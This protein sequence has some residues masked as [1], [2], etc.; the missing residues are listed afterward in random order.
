MQKFF[1]SILLNLFVLSVF[2]GELRGYGEVE[3]CY[4]VP[5]KSIPTCDGSAYSDWGGY[6]NGVNFC[7]VSSLGC[8]M[9]VVVK[10]YVS[11]EP[12]EL[13][14]VHDNLITITEEQWVADGRSWAYSYCRMEYP[15]VGRYIGYIDGMLPFD[16]V[17]MCSLLYS[18]TDYYS[19]YQNQDDAYEA[20]WEDYGYG[21]FGSSEEQDAFFSVFFE[22]QPEIPCEI[23]ISRLMVST[24]DA[25]RL[26]AEKYTEPSLV[27]Q[28]N[29]EKCYVK[30]ESGVGNLNINF[31]GEIYH[32]V[33]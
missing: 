4:V 3:R 22:P 19:C 5:D 23:G 1:V 18:S 13:Y 21:F 10:G 20:C 24:G 33:E 27:V 14:E 25:F 26:W 30:L 7:Y 31:N 15:Y 28:Y 17:Y 16:D 2:A 11:Y 6:S 29:D 8:N 12:T 9:P 32:A